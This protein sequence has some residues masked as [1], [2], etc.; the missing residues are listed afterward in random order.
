MTLIVVVVVIVG[1]SATFFPNRNLDALGREALAKLRAVADARELFRRV[2]LEDVTE[3]RGKDGR[4]ATFNWE[5]AL[6]A[7]WGL[8]VAE[9]ESKSRQ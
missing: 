5:V 9:G 4:P 7:W 2:D 1:S 8:D 3:D 6:L